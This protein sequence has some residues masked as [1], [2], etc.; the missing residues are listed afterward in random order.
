MATRTTL[1]PQVWNVVLARLVSSAGAEA[2]FFIGLWGKAAFVFDGTPTEL[3][4]M[5][6][7]IGTGAIVGSLVGGALVDRFDARRMVIVTEFVVVPSSL[8]L[9]LADDMTSLIAIGFV[10]WMAGSALETAITSLPPVMVG[11][12]QLEQ[13]NARLE[14]ANWLALVIGP[15][16]GA[17]LAGAFSIN[18]VFILDA[19]T[20]LAAI[21][22]VL[23]VH[24]DPRLAA[25]ESSSGSGLSEIT[26]GLRYAWRTPPVRLTLYLQSLVGVAFGVFIAPE[27]LFFRDVLGTGVEAI[28]YV[29]VVFGVGLFAGSVILERSHGRWTSFRGNILL[30]SAAGVGAMVYTGTASLVWVVVG[31]VL[32]SVPLGMSLPMSRTLAQ[33]GSAPAYVGRVMGAFGMVA[34][35]AGIVPVIFAPALAAA[36]GVQ[37]VLV[38]SGAAA[39]VFSPL[40]WRAAR[41]LDEDGVGAPLS[42]LPVQ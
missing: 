31:A 13:A 25:S 14:G 7:V 17:L 37:L 26:E 15:G 24:L 6:A 42:P 38:L 27:P 23:R 9:I 4:V 11:P 29:N 41:R 33:R 35:G 2:A 12:D 16:V 1:A 39:A 22:M 40:A 32:W 19:L 18:S 28:G 8:A 30:S 36:L 21:A 3:A 10:S 5:S 34:A 20:S